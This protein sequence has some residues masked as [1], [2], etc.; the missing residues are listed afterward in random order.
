MIRLEQVGFQSRRR[1]SVNEPQA[2]L[3]NGTTFR[4]LGRN[5]QAHRVPG[6]PCHMTLDTV[7]RAGHRPR[8]ALLEIAIDISINE[9]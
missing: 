6:Q 4:V 3:A 5:R 2:V 1:I 8:S 9:E 7:W